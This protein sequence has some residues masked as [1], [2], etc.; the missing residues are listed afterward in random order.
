MNDRPS[1][2][3]DQ[4]SGPRV[5]VLSDVLR[6]VRLTGAVFFDVHASAPW[7]AESPLSA[8]V[9]AGLMPGA[10][11][12]ISFHVL[13]SGHCHAWQVGHEPL[14]LSAGDL[15]IFPHGHAHC[16]ASEPG[17]RAPADLALFRRDAHP[18]LPV[19]ISQGQ[20]GDPKAHLICG[21]LGCDSRPFNPLL[22]TLPPVMLLRADSGAGGNWLGSFVETALAECSSPTPGGETV[23]ARLSELLFIEAVRRHVA[24]LPAETTGW[25]AGLRDPA[26][27]NALGLLHAQPAA[28]WTIELLADRSG[29]SRSVMAQRFA[30]LVGVP[31]M[32]Y[33]ARWRMQLAANLLATG[34]TKIAAVAREVGYEA[35]AAFSRAFKKLTGKSPSQWKATGGPG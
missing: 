28:P 35:E 1:A 24:A 5:D 10:Q 16:L 30:E 23:L 34:T 15:V 22:E 13:T 32:Q 8:S 12:V 9:A 11:H 26:V 29:V 14:V 27:G 3:V 7:V 21:F 17:L 2:L 6:A 4:S 33:L 25:L 31:P 18:R 20:G 19:R